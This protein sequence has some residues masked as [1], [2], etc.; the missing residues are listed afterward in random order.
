[1]TRPRK[2]SSLSRAVQKANAYPIKYPMA[3]PVPENATGWTRRHF[4]HVVGA[5]TLGST[6]GRKV[7]AAATSDGTAATTAAAP[8]PPATRDPVGKQPPLMQIGILLSTF[9]RPPLEARL[10]AARAGGLEHVQLSLDCAGRPAMPDKIPPEL[11]GRIRREAAARRITIASIQGTYNKSHPDAAQ[12]ESGLRR[13][14]VLAGLGQELGVP[15]IHLG[16]GPR[17][18][19]S[20]W[21]RHPDNDLPRR[22][23][24]WLRPCARR[25]TSPGR[26]A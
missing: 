21:R 4:L 10:D 12:R 3:H 14:R 1:M 16:S 11:A 24:T 23:R 13:L 15:R 17:D 7:L 2:P 25:P 8:K 19:V 9:V 26:R 5:L 6:C 20:R 18:R 22:G